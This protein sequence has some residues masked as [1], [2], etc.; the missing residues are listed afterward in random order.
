ML[1]AAAERLS[2]Q[3]GLSWVRGRAE[4]LPFRGEYFDAVLAVTILCF[5]REPRAVVSEAFRVLRPG[6]RLVI[7]EFGRFSSW[8]FVR[9][10]RGR[11]G[12]EPWRRARFFRPRDLAQ[13]VHGAGF[14]DLSQSG[15]V[16][17]PPIRSPRLLDTARGAWSLLGRRCWPGLGL[18]VV[19]GRRPS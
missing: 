16:F 11:F 15:A 6:G 1:R 5:A 13:V 18:P 4:A 14:T 8:A 7:S 3:S 10:L 12:S 9:R 17:Y 2:G 19:S